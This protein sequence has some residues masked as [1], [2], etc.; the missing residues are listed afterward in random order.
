MG[1]L[2]SSPENTWKSSVVTRGLEAKRRAL[3]FAAERC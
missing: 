3:I 2:N 1:E